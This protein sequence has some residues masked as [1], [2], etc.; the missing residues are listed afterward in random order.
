MTRV[1]SGVR[2]VEL[3]SWTY[4]PSAGVALADWG[5]DVIKVEGV[6]S[7]DPGRALVVGGFTREAARADADFILELSNRG[8]R[9]VA[10]DIK[11]ETGR[12]LFGRLL[13]SADV[14]LT[15]WLPG[16]L[17]R[18][19]L[20]VEDIRSFNPNI[21]IARGT[22]LGVRGPDRDRGG[23]DAAT[24]L[25]RGGVAYTLTPFG[26]ENPAVQGPA[27]GDLQGGATL[28]G[29]VCAAL[30]HRE[31]TGEPSIVDS[32]LLAQAMWAIAPS[33]SV[34][35][36][37]DIDGIPGAPPGLAINPLVARYKTKDDR[38]IQ[39]VFLQPDKYWAGFCKR[40]G[41][42]EL[43]NDERFVPSGN[44]IANAAEAT[45]IFANA[46]A[47]QDLAH[48]RRVLQDEPG[49]WGAL[50]TPKETL[51]D[52]QV[53]PNGYVITNVD[54]RGEKYR[55]VAAPVQFDETPPA[56]ARAPEHGQHTEEVLLE[57][58]LDWDEIA[59]AKD[60]KAIL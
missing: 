22:G 40:M 25:A 15:N 42:V 16:A 44:L 18:A 53:E 48:W 8:K 14:F 31:R 28:A 24:Y 35:D 9:S 12:E 21:I 54:D 52:P 39:L 11:S 4:V 34:A 17:E 43:V 2:V 13:A 1:L 32:S 20:T 33:I 19:R 51:N 3:A 5:A 41:L 29:G 10:I 56:P 7:G 46:F 38:W 6:A 58:D 60:S 37:F 45:A 50:A 59:R 26:T 57:L 30:F 49:V 23:F 55:I 27:F 47:A 36:L